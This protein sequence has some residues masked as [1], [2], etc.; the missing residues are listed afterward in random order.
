MASLEL[1][2]YKNPHRLFLYAA[3]TAA[4]SLQSCPLCATPLTAAHHAP[5]SLGFSRQEHWSELPFPSPMHESEKWKGSHWVLSDSSR[6]HGLQPTRLVRP[7]EFPGKSTGVGCH[8]LLHS[9]CRALAKLGGW[10][11][12]WPGLGYVAYPW[13]SHWGPCRGLG[14]SDPTS[15]RS[16][17]LE[18]G[19]NLA[20]PYGLKKTVAAHSSTLAWKVPWTEE[21][22]RLQSMGSRRVGR[23]WATS[24][25][26]RSSVYSCHLFLI[27]SASVRSIPFL[28]FIE[29]IFAGNIPLVS[30][31]FLKRSLVF[32]I[33]LCSSISLHWSLKKAFLSPL[34]ILWNSAFQWVYLSFSPFLYTSLLFI[35][36]FKAS[37]E[38]HFAFLH[39]FFWGMVLIPCLLYNV[40]NLRPQF[41]TYSVYQI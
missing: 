10:K 16:L 7:W 38:S 34:A 40:T 29:H 33:L 26:Y 19:F 23:D 22:G 39:F 25:L 27:S 20:L 8:C 41:I 36:I 5:P 37:S 18:R 17:T 14:F 31:I 4:K 28:S 2:N 15:D 12:S 3:A 1:N 21:P 32:P 13:T 6:P 24:F 30:L 11:D 35:A 9:F